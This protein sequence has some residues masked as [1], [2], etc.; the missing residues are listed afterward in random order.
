MI[1][2]FWLSL[3]T[4]SVKSEKFM[5]I[6]FYWLDLTKFLKSFIIER[7]LLYIYVPKYSWF[8]HSEKS[9][10]KIHRNVLKKIIISLSEFSIQVI[11][12]IKVLISYRQCG[13][14]TICNIDIKMFIRIWKIPENHFSK[15]LFSFLPPSFPLLLP[16]PPFSP[17]P[18][19]VD[20]RVD[21][22]MNIRKCT[23]NWSEY[24][25]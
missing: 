7:N 14:G 15:K 5:I 8:F 12:V 23:F 10:L 6:I 22:G 2:Y 20:Q 18:R 21:I 19:P 4:V 13:K 11:R 25:C 17:L 9:F 3:S 16:F 24:K 1:E